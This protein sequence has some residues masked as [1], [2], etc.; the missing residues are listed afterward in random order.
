MTGFGQNHW[1]QERHHGFVIDLQKENVP[2]V[3]IKNKDNDV[4]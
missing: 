1:N 2:C 3:L 4:K